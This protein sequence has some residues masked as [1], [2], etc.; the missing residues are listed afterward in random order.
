MVIQNCSVALL[1]GFIS[2]CYVITMCHCILR[3]PAPTGSAANRPDQQFPRPDAQ[4][5]PVAALAPPQPE[6]SPIPKCREAATG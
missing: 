4:T 1:K 6:A 2:G 5:L 3:R